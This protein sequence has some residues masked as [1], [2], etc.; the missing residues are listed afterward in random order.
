[1][2]YL[3]EL[4]E[5]QQKYHYLQVLEDASTNY[6]DCDLVKCRQVPTF[7]CRRV[8]V[9]CFLCLFEYSRV[10]HIDYKNE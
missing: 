10:K 6:R 8:H 4:R 1:M 7:A 3:T 2:T 5:C 9:L